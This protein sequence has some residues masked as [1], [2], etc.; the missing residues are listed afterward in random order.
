[1]LEESLE[2]FLRSIKTSIYR[3]LIVSK[4]RVLFMRGK[5][6][7]SRWKKQM[8]Q[9]Q[10]PPTNSTP[11]P[12]NAIVRKQ[13]WSSLPKAVSTGTERKSYLVIWRDYFD[14]EEIDPI[15]EKLTVGNEKELQDYVTKEFK[16]DFMASAHPW[17][18]LYTSL[19][20]RKH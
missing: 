14:R 5:N 8:K 12:E 7:K 17:K 19:I 11:S 4:E 18:E 10:S 15:F 9:L 13:S 16:G 6:S 1:M 20:E 3:R 2:R